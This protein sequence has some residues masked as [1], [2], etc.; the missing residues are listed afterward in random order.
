MGELA[1]VLS[2]Q[3][4]ADVK[5]YLASGN[6]TF[7]AESPLA[8]AQALA[9]RAIGEAFGFEA[10]V[11]LYHRDDVAAIVAAWPHP[12]RD[13]HHRYVLLC[14]GVA[15][16]L[17]AAMQEADAQALITLRDDVVYWSCPRGATLSDP[18]GK[19]VGNRRW[20]TTTTNRNLNTL[21]KML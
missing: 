19:V 15:T 16:E 17:H 7:S 6:I 13:D 5:T 10:R 3:G 4:F 1:S 12:A 11:L 20:A 14:E 9:E 2:A 8:Q 21:E 18:V